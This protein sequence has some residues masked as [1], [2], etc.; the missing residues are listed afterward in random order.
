MGVANHV[1][2]QIMSLQNR[3]HHGGINLVKERQ[4]LKRIKQAKAER[5]RIIAED[6]MK[7][8]AS[9]KYWGLQKVIGSKR[10]IEDL[11]KVIHLF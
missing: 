6:A 5:E 1:N 4:F 7:P 11:I 10:A 3:M 8:A 2:Y 9:S